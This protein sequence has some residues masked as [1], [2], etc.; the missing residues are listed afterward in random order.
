MKSRMIE[1]RGQREYQQTQ[2]FFSTGI[3]GVTS[4]KTKHVAIFFSSGELVYI[5]KSVSF[6]FF[7]VN[8]FCVLFYFFLKKKTAKK[9]YILQ[10][11]LLL[12]DS[13]FWVQLSQYQSPSGTSVI[14]GLRQYIWQPLSHQSHS[15]NLASSQERRHTLQD[16]MQGKEG[17]REAWVSSKRLGIQDYS[18]GMK[19]FMHA[20]I[21]CNVLHYYYQ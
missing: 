5:K 11:I 6:S 4:T 17:E 15:S 9:M 20:L 18:C 10:V 21:Y 1:G 16:C 7:S 19:S 8:F 13:T 2:L 3:L 14:L 12:S